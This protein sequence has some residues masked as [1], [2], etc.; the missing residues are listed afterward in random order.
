MLGN[1]NDSYNI[2]FLLLDEI[3]ISKICTVFVRSTG[4]QVSANACNI[5]GQ[6]ITGPSVNPDTRADPGKRRVLTPEIF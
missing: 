1:A 4:T 3:R 5:V 2:T 6:P